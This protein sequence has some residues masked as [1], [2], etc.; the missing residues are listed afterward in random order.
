M[1]GLDVEQLDELEKL[2]SELLEEPWNKGKGRLRELTLREALV[3]TSGY[4]RNNI[5]EEVWPFK[6]NRG[7][8][9]VAGLNRWK[10]LS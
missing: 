1:S 7:G 5:T 8:V 10:Q 4:A 9:A 2:A 6:V 3:V